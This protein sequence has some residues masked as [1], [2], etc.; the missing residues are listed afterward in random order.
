[1]TK[2]LLKNK[3]YFFPNRHKIEN[4]Y[5][6]LGQVINTTIHI[7]R[8]KAKNVMKHTIYSLI[9]FEKEFSYI[10]GPLINMYGN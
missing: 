10:H 4:K 6:Y 3:I 7:M 9:L 2:H 8:T 1:M 5:M